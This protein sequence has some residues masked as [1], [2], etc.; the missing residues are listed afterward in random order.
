MD[1]NI[2]KNIINILE[3]GKNLPLDY[4]S[5][6]FPIN[7]KEYE[8]TYNN[9]ISREVLL[10]INEEPQAVPFQV[11]KEFNCS[12][13][14]EWKN[15]LIF[16][17][18]LQALKTIYENKDPLIKDKVKG[19][20]KLIYIDPP[21]ATES[22][23]VAKD[24][25]KAYS[26]KI[27]GSEFIEFIRQRLILA[28]EILSD[29]GS[30][31]VHLDMKKYHYI[32]VIMD[33]IFGENNFRNEIIWQSSSSGKTVKQN[34]AKDTQFICW[35]SKTELY[36][37]NKVFTSLSPKTLKMYRMDDNDGRGKYRLYPLQKTDG[38]TIGT[39]YDY[40]DENKKVW[41]CPK[42]GWRMINEKLKE[43]ELDNRLYFGGKTLQEKAYWNERD[44]EGK[45]AN[46]LWIDCPNLQGN[47]NEISGYPTQKPL[48]L[49]SRIIE[50]TTNKND[51]ILDFFAGSGTSLIAAENLGRRWIGCDIGKLSMYTIQKRLLKSSNLNS[52]FCLVNAG[53]YN[54]S[55]IFGLDKN[56]YYDFVMD[57]FRVD[58]KPHKINGI[59]V[60]G[61]RYGD[62]VKVFAYQDF[63]D[64]I[65][66]NE[67]YINEL[68]A[69]IGDKVGN[70]FYI[71]APEMNIDIIGD[72]YKVDD[73]K[74]YLLRIP[75]Q[76]IADLHKRKFKKL[77]QP[78][79]K[80]L[81]NSIEDSIGFYFNEIPEVKNQIIKKGE[82]FII[83]IDEVSS[84]FINIDDQQDFINDILAMV[85]I[86]TSDGENF[87]M[88]SVFFADDIRD[89]NKYKIKIK[90]S[91][92]LSKKIKIIYIDIYGNEFKEVLEV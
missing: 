54:L 41:K 38:P 28:K 39:K 16:G 59:Q 66:I 44:N 19:M 85:L 43:L 88:Q 57:L 55:S 7:H 92:I 2:I 6:L 20:V 74:Y 22:D 91:D 15:L 51:L 89:G 90:Y 45:L 17:D 84:Q 76:V 70:R 11:E 31:F 30:I 1:E 4:L 86:D 3:S 35:Y 10:S 18:N 36:T 60:D 79:N 33:E 53:C 50:M 67:D 73:V 58:N 34:L 56:K 62:W 21:F 64:N 47:N 81:I 23:F 80:K 13:K 87:I 5:I 29:E 63:K 24:G 26:D 37:F 65:G 77:Q 32:K 48:S 27:K 52:K 61:K 71:I 69:H 75:Y 72:Y 49:L 8:L 25:E 42:K 9:K 68:H 83:L 14:D 46:N 12:Y 78:N 82:Y 40:V